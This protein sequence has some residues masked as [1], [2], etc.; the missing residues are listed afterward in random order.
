MGGMGGGMP[1]GMGGMGGGMPG[2]MGGMGGGMPGEF[3][4]TIP[5]C[6]GDD[7]NKISHGISKK[8]ICFQVVDII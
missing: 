1:G 4:P 8:K 3:F 7:L 5:T 2:G 6:L